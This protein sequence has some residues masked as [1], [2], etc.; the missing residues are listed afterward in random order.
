MQFSKLVYMVFFLF[1]LGG[2]VMADV[3]GNN[4]YYGGGNRGSGRNQVC[5]MYQKYL[6]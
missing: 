1:V 5:T 2:S 4:D 6:C 3:T